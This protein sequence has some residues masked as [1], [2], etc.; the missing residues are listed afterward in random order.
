MSVQRRSMYKVR[1]KQ[2][3]K[4]GRYAS[5]YS[6]SSSLSIPRGISSTSKRFGVPPVFTTKLR[7]VDNFNST[8]SGAI[9]TRYSFRLNSIFDPDFTGGGHQPMYRDQLIALYT[10]YVVLGSVAKFYFNQISD[11]GG[12]TDYGPILCGVVKDEDGSVSTVITDLQENNSSEFTYLTRD[13]G[14]S[15]T[16]TC[17]YS[18]KYD[19]GRSADDDTVGASAGNNPTQTSFANVYLANLGNTALN[20]TIS[21]SVEIEFLV[22]MMRQNNALGS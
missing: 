14:G 17:T 10:N 5:R 3:T 7:Y 21:W 2:T 16:L 18:P 9:P 22:R 1:R 15:Q 20:P 4:K 19:L 13:N 12:A 6:P 11:D 8:L